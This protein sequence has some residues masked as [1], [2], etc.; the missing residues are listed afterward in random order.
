MDP[1]LIASIVC[2]LL[3]LLL[4]AGFAFLVFAFVLGLILLRRRGKKNV[5]AAEAVSAGVE[6]VSMVF[7][8][9]AAGQMEAVTSD[10]QDE[11]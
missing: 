11:D 6:S 9:N 5:T 3:S 8:R 7:R 4:C 2:S 1:T 10:G